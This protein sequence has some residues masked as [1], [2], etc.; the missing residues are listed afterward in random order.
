M[1]IN[2]ETQKNMQQM[3]NQQQPMEYNANIYQNNQINNYPPNQKEEGRTGNFLDN[4]LGRSETRQEILS[5]YSN[6]FK[7][8]MQFQFRN[9]FTSAGSFQPKNNLPT[10]TYIGSKIAINKLK[11]KENRTSDTCYSKQRRKRKR[12]I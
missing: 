6:K 2:L 11:F 12:K 10:I 5:E 7:N 3:P 8:S 1:H 4:P 9:S